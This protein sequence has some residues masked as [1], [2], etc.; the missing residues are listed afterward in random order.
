MS[1]PVHPD[2]LPAGVRAIELA[3]GVPGLAFTHPAF[4][5]TLSLYGGQLLGYTPH[6]GQPLF[7]LSPTAL[8][9]PGKA[10]RGG[11]PLCWPW[12][13]PAPDGTG[14]PAH[15]FARN[16]PW[17]LTS[18]LAEA[19]LDPTFVIGGRLNSA[20]ANA[21]LGSGDYIVV[22]ADESDASFMHLQPMIA[23]VT[24]VDADHLATHDGNFER[25][26]QSFI[27]FLHN[28]PFHGL[29]V[30]CADD[31]EVAA[32]LPRIARPMVTYG[33]DQQADLCIHKAD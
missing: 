6:G 20:G 31:K 8:L 12:F 9:Q 4:T 2:L 21:K 5:A 18:V 14:R 15:G 27:D 1:H 7:Y 10:I 28:L 11:V 17:R 22:E 25:L 23:I 3:P 32:L 19:G 26:K 29:A 24:N 16:L 13:G 33:I 30:V